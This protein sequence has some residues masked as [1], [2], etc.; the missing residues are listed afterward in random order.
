M[1]RNVESA[2]VTEAR[3]QGV[4]VMKDLLGREGGVLTT[5]EVAEL[6]GITPRAVSKRRKHGS[7]L[8]VRL[9]RREYLYPAW[10]FD[11][12]RILEGLDDVMAALRVDDPWMRLNFFLTGDARLG[13]RTPLFVLRKGDVDRVTAAAAMFGEHGAP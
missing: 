9:G 3:R 4:L 1:S 12:R 11:R 13:G 2:P 10:Q 8:A 5:G 7:L 6:C